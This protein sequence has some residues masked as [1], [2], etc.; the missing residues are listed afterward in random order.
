MVSSVRRQHR[1]AR[2][3]RLGL[4]LGQGA[5]EHVDVDHRGRSEAAPLD[6]DGLLT[7]R[8]A[9]LQHLPIGPEH[10]NAAQ[11]QLHQLQGHQPV[12]DAAEL[13][14]PK[15]DHV[16]LDPA[17]GEPV[18]EALHEGLGLVV[19]K[20][21]PV[22]QVDTDD[23][24]RLLLQRR[25]GVE[26]VDVQND[27][28]RLV[29]GMRLKLQPHPSVALVVPLI[30]AGH[31]GVGEGEKRRSI[32]STVTQPVDIEL[33]LVVEHRLQP[34]HR[35]V[36]IGFAVDGVAHGHV[37]GRYGLG[38]RPGGTPYPE[39]PSG[40]LLA[41]PDLR[42]RPVPP[43]IQV[44]PQRLL[45]GIGA[46]VAHGSTGATSIPRI[47]VPGRSTRAGLVMPKHCTWADRRRH[48]LTA[49]CATIGPM[50]AAG[51]PGPLALVGSGEYLPQMAALEAAL[52]VGRPPRYVQ[53][54]TAAVPD[55]EPH[56]RRK[57]G[58]PW[59]GRRRTASAS[60]P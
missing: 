50:N 27:L 59:G 31:N 19:L 57:L 46:E 2:D 29:A 4:E 39:K 58:I 17:G 22:E 55:E 45:M 16:D 34:T 51:S 25:L 11:P 26:H 9:G 49:S 36:P 28:A 24:D 23:S 54:A 56:D 60:R 41:R 20:E 18:Q 32:A 30:A 6:Q 43:R 3:G 12:V 40:D 10:G 42:D 53:L 33:I 35:Y 47:S 37:V 52:L 21:S 15:L 5:F 48:G 14:A 44:D 8:L 13:D 38:D 7:E 1:P